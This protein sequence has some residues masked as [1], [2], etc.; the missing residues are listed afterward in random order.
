MHFLYFL[1]HDMLSAVTMQI[2]SSGMRLYH[3]WWYCQCNG[4]S[5]PW[6]VEYLHS[7]LQNVTFETGVDF[8]DTELLK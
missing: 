8:V 4:S 6:N 5:F 7:R 1:T 2:P 3:L